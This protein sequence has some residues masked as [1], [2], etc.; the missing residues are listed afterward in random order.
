MCKIVG[1]LLVD[2]QLIV[3]YCLSVVMLFLFYYETT[4][5]HVLVIGVASFFVKVTCDMVRANPRSTDDNT[6]LKR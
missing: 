5:I 3:F 6:T 4:Y 1:I 2:I